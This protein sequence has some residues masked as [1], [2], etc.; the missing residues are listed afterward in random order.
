MTIDDL[1]EEYRIYHRDPSLP[2]GEVS[3]ETQTKSITSSHAPL[4]NSGS[5]E[6]LSANCDQSNVSPLDQPS[7]AVNEALTQY[8]LVKLETRL[9]A[10]IVEME[11]R[12]LKG[13]SELRTHVMA[14]ATNNDQMPAILDEQ[15]NS[16]K[17]KQN[18]ML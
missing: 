6:Q 10:S 16:K 14:S 5:T 8:D 1:E 4:L 15:T 9:R 13:V 2:G 3:G 11:N 7:P 12:I 17:R 18:T